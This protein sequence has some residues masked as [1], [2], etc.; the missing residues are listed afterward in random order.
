VRVRNGQIV[1]I[2]GLMTQELRDDRTGLPVL[3]DVPVFGGLFRQKTGSLSK[4]ELVILIKPSVIGD[5]GPW[6]EAE[7]LPPVAKR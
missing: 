4:R 2:G 7:A 6:P 3:S 1:A 5:E